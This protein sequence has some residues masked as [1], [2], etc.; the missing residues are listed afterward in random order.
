MNGR[1]AR[2][3]MWRQVVSCLAAYALVLHAILI[4]ATTGAAAKAV[5]ADGTPR[6]ELCLHDGGVFD[7]ASSGTPHDP[8]KSERH[9]P[10]CVAGGAAFVPPK[11]FF[12][13]CAPEAVVRLQA[14]GLN[15]DLPP[16][17]KL[18]CE[19]PRGPPLP[20]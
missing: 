20:A 14:P 2:T 16:S 3:G 11:P 18:L 19:Q 13:S 5:K 15:R 12:V 10:F 7:T 4:G 1:R 17:P 8:S 9:C 6:F